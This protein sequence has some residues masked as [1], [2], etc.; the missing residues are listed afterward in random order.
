MKRRQ[1]TIIVTLLTQG[2]DTPHNDIFGFVHHGSQTQKDAMTVSA[3]V[4]PTGVLL[5]LTKGVDAAYNE[6]GYGLNQYG[7]QPQQQG[8]MYSVSI[9][10]Y[11]FQDSIR[12]MGI[13][14]ASSIQRNSK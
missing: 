2:V 3:F 1:T 9:C 14:L 8:S 11:G 6:H 13:T 4:L 12:I 7:S 10:V 5:T